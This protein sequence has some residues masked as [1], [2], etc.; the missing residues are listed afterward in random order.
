MFHVIY[1]AKW[2]ISMVHLLIIKFNFSK[3][4]FCSI[5]LYSYSS[6]PKNTWRANQKWQHQIH[7]HT[8]VLPCFTWTSTSVGNVS[9]LFDPFFPRIFPP[10]GT[11]RNNL[12]AHQNSLRTCYRCALGQFGGIPCGVQIGWGIKQRELSIIAYYTGK[13][14]IMIMLNS[15]NSLVHYKNYLGW[16][17]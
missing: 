11:C 3:M 1:Q 17:G 12:F 5:D 4:V 15:S 6:H 14:V 10:K 8:N 2:H 9:C 13:M 7:T 16:S